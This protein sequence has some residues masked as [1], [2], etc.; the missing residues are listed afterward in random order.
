LYEEDGRAE[1]GWGSERTDENS[2][3]FNYNFYRWTVNSDIRTVHSQ[4]DADVVTL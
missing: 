3:T 2:N 4:T 1:C